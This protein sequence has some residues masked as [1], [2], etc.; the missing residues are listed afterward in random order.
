VT[1]PRFVVP[2]PTNLITTRCS[3]RRFFVTPDART[4]G[5]FLYCLGEAA[6]RFGVRVIV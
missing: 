2:G 4:L 3:E 5:I 6:Q 1:V